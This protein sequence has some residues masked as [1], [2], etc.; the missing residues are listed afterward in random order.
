MGEVVYVK[1]E[2]P[3]IKNTILTAMKIIVL[4]P[5]SVIVMKCQLSRT[6]PV[7][8]KNRFSIPVKMMIGKIGLTLLSIILIGIPEIKK[9]KIKKT[10]PIP[11]PTKPFAA[12]SITIYKTVSKSLILGSSRCSKDF[13]GKY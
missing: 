11:R 8:M 9:E 10:I 7:R 5:S 13:P 12:K 3:Q 2:V 1:S 4:R 6:L